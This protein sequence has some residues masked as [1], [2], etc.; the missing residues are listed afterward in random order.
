MTLDLKNDRAVP[1]FPA[2][3]S[4]ENAGASTAFTMKSG[5]GEAIRGSVFQITITVKI[6]KRNFAV[7]EIFTV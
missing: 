1:T 6:P 7:F 4:I 3:L 5:T 2:Q